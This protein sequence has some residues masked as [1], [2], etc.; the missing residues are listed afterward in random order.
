MTAL[1]DVLRHMASWGF[2]KMNPQPS[3]DWIVMVGVLRT[4]TQGEVC[5]EIGVMPR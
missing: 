4:T 1:P 2:T 5:C 3:V